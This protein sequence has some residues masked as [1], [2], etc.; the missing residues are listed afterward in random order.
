MNISC[1]CLFYTSA[2]PQYKPISS[3]CH[4]PINLEAEAA[5][6]T[7]TQ[8]HSAKLDTPICLE[9]IH[10]GYGD[11]YILLPL[12]VAVWFNKD[13]KWT[14]RLLN[15]DAGLGQGREGALHIVADAIRGDSERTKLLLGYVWGE[16][17]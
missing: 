16:G 17:G 2:S 3:K 15:A 11:L 12:G 13:V 14:K 6:S 4:H 10:N 1:S 5:A 7:G 9:A 8:S